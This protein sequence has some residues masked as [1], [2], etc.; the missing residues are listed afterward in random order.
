LKPRPW[1][2]RLRLSGLTLRRS[3]SGPRASAN[4]HARMTSGSCR[5]P[6]QRVAN[7]LGSGPVCHVRPSAPE[8]RRHWIRA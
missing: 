1:M 2:V 4:P 7:R 6:R 8:R 3:T 5:R